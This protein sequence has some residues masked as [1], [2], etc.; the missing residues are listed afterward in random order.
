MLINASLA[1]SKGRPKNYI[2]DAEIRHIA[3][4][5]H[6]WQPVDKF[7]IVITLAAVEQ[8]DW[9]LSPSRFISTGEAE[10]HRDIQSI[11]D[12]LATAHAEAETLDGELNSILRALGYQPYG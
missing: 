4:V 8:N 9:N 3:E 6:A 1:F 5:F 2:P 10:Q 11:I 7:A 12:E